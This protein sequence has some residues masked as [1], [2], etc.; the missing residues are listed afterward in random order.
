MSCPKTWT[1]Q[2]ALDK[3][4]SRLFQEYPIP[5]PLSIWGPD[6]CAGTSLQ[7]LIIMTLEDL[8]TDLEIYE[9]VDAYGIATQLPESTRAVTAV[10]LHMPF[11]G[12]RYVKW[13]YDVDTKICMVRYVPAKIYYKRGIAICDLMH[14]KGARMVYIRS[15]ILF[16]MASKELSYLTTVNL[17]TDSG[18]VDLNALSTFKDNM[19]QKVQLLHEDICL[20]SNG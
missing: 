14:L 18:G 2:D 19:Q 5:E 12:N 6:P 13:S 10:K 3:I 1:P 15:E 11:Q 9:S 20:Y 16:R 17:S 7:E 4:R 8:S